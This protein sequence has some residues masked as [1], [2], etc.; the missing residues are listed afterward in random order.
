MHDFLKERFD[1]TLKIWHTIY[2][3]PQ[4]K[5]VQNIQPVLDTIDPLPLNSLYQVTQV[6]KSAALALALIYQDSSDEKRITLEEAVN[7]AR[8]DEHF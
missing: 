8:V 1:I 5:S 7:I 4:D 2:M 3:D 6:S